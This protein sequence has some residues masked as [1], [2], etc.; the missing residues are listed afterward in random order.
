MKL[1][2]INLVTKIIRI[3]GKLKNNQALTTFS[4]Y[5]FF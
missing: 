3:L 1:F 5:I 4:E 2:I